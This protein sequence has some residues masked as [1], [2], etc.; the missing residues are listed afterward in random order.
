[1]ALG[2]AASEDR[3]VTGHLDVRPAD[4]A[5]AD[6]VLAVLDEA[7]AWLSRRGIRQ[8]P[9]SFRRE[10]MEP[11]LTEGR[12]LL[13]RRNGSVAGTLTLEWTDPLWT[14]ASAAGYLH[15]LAVRRAAAG[16]GA[17]LLTWAGTAVRGRDRGLLRL[18]CPAGNMPL[19]AYYDRAGFH[20]VGDVELSAAAA[21]WSPPGT[22]LSLYQ[23]NLDDPSPPAL[24]C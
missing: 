4:P 24:S 1:M 20:H 19:R 10:W 21:L 14:D 9:P 7:A 5:E 12:V 23:R 18:D 6:A 3:H 11:A 8:W 16:L 22:M 17:R 15:R 13:A 2:A